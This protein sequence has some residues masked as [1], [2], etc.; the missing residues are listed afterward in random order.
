ML[1]IAQLVMALIIVAGTLSA[2]AYW[3]ITDERIAAGGA[4]LIALL[5]CIALERILASI[6]AAN[7][8]R[9]FGKD[10]K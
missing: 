4:T 1:R 8:K 10:W 7:L 9:E 2:N 6:A 5:A 3:Q